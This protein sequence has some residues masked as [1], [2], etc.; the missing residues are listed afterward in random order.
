MT[1]EQSDSVYD[2]GT[3]VDA[4]P[5]EDPKSP[6]DPV[7]KPVQ[8]KTAIDVGTD[9]NVPIQLARERHPDFAIPANDAVISVTISPQ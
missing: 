4:P 6:P 3:E 8:P 7:Q 1:R 5:G 2:A 9:E